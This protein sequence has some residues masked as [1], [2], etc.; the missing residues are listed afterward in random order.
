MIA[1]HQ[2]KETTL[3]ALATQPLNYKNGVALLDARVHQPQFVEENPATE[4]EVKEAK[5]Q[6]AFG[7]NCLV[8]FPDRNLGRPD[9]QAAFSIVRQPNEQ[10]N[11]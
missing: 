9:L 1:M 11:G 5:I 7:Q 8:Q 4:Y 10:L 3:R 6:A 2:C